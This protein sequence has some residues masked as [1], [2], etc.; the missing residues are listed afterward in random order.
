MVQPLLHSST[1]TRT[2]AKE[3]PDHLL[4]LL[5][6]GLGAVLIWLGPSISGLDALHSTWCRPAGQVGFSLGD[7][8]NFLSAHHCPVCYVGAAMILYGLFMLVGQKAALRRQ[9]AD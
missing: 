3:F 7:L 1:R 5:T 8:M 4:A 9:A 2:L 6:M